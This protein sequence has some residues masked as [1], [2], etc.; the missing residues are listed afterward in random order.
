M[1]TTLAKALNDGL[2]AAMERDPKVLVMGEDVGRLGGVFRITDGLQKDFGE[3]RVLDTPLS[4]SG[5]IG[6][7][8]GLAVRGFRPVCEIQFDG[9][10]FPG[11]D[12]IVSQLAKLRYRTQGAVPV[13]VVVRIPF[14]G[15]IGAVE[16][17]SESPESL[18]AHVAGLKVVACSNPADAHWMIQQAILSDDPVIFF[19]P[20]R[21]YWEK[22]EID[23][24]L[25][26]AP[27]LHSARVVR[28]GSALTLATYGPMVKTC[29]DAATAAAEDGQDL[30]VIDLRTLSPLDLGP[31]AESVRRTGR[32]VVVSEA[33]SESSITSEVAAR[34]QQECFFSLEAPVLRVTGF[35]TP[36]PPSRLED[37]FLP[38]LD[39]VLDAVDRSLAW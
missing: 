6:A 13:P 24:D 1:A 29:L 31:V 8:V 7:A 23:T 26:A 33:P 3:Q 18:F 20:K 38:D 32:L 19:E 34:I 27:P 36:Y 2:R 22:G 17:H 21:R 5:I 11:Y 10:V 28:P 25:G 9:F 4:E 30:E 16:H 37:E 12:Q 14:G 35:D 15:G 39:R